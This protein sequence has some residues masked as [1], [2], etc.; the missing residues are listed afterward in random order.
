MTNMTS[1]T[2][3]TNFSLSICWIVSMHEGL[4]PA[5]FGE[6][7]LYEV[8][9]KCSRLKESILV[10]LPRSSEVWKP[11]LLKIFW[12]YQGHPQVQGDYDPVGHF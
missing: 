5:H 9:S 4:S 7:F 2:L 12:C 3:Q 11:F 1:I 8:V 6:I 10:L